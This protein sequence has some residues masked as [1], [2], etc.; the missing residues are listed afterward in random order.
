VLWCVRLCGAVLH[1]MSVSPTARAVRGEAMVE[2]GKIFQA[3]KAPEGT[4]DPMKQV[5]EAM[6][7]ACKADGEEEE[8]EEGEA[9]GTAQ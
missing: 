9:G 8:G 3:A 6:R 2:L 5:E 4:G 1:D 7:R